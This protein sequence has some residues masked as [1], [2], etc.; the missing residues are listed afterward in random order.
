MS[1][2]IFIQQVLN[3][4]SLGSLYSL[5]AI[6]YTMVYGILALI[7]FAHGDIF[8]IGAYIAFFA[9]AIYALPW[10][11]AAILTV[12]LTA[13]VGM[14]IERVAYRPLRD[15]PRI[16]LLITA[17]GVAF[18]IENLAIVTLGARPKGFPVPAMMAT[19][20][21]ISG[22]RISGVSLWVP[23]LSI[24][25]LG[26]LLYVIYR[27]KVGMAMRAVAKDIEATRLM[28]VNVDKVIMY[29]FAIGSGLAAAG[30]MMWAS[31]Y[32]QIQPL[33]GMYP[34]WKAFTAAVVGGIGNITGAMIGGLII[35]LVEILT[36]A[37]FPSISGFRDAIVFAILIIF[38][39]V[40][41][42][43]LM[44]EPLKEKV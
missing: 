16:S 5:I 4:I 24:C 3:G 29:T 35:G 41:P 20:F 8:M 31:K 11:L 28:G 26:C 13:C 38:L 42:T 19:N 14:L 43:G 23:V 6:G 9:V 17:V 34:G 18:F 2:E 44:G 33:M 15:E 37:F 22:I 7:N 21:D 36:V 1:I 12:L 32:P 27:T 39:L 40:K 10:W 25:L 30:G